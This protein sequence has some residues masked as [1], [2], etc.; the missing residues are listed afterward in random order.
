MFYT[1]KANRYTPRKEQCI[2]G[3]RNLVQEVKVKIQQDNKL[4]GKND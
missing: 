1:A 3:D 4:S 2:H